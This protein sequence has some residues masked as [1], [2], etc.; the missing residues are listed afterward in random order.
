MIL[1]DT[2]ALVDSLSG[3]K[4]SA[5][6]LRGLIEKGERLVLPS[7]VLYEW[8]RG[9]RHPAELRAQEELFPRDNAVPFGPA[10][11][12]L[13][14]ELYGKVTRPRGREVDLSIAACAVL[15]D[16]SLW[17]LNTG[18]FKDVPGLKLAAPRALSP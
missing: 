15:R 2:S 18:D 4:R 14:A 11:A 6:L 12:A 7:L 9:P 5:P 10:E 13:A 17:T 16:A 3:A 8:L 1:V